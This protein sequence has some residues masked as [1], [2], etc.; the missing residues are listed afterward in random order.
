MTDLTKGLQ[1][2]TPP[3]FVPWRIRDLELE[4]L[5]DG[6]ALKKVKRGYYTLKCEPLPGL[7][8]SLGFH[9]H[10]FDVLTEFEFFV[11]WKDENEIKESYAAFQNSFEKAF[12]PPT[13]TST[14]SEGFP[15]HEWTVP[16]ARIIHL[17]RERHGPEEL[18]RITRT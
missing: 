7:H 16:G 11:L 8:C 17:V 1:L 12:G 18:M 4:D 2:T 10:E 15:S 13:K 5:F 14:G 6:F 3:K 9:L